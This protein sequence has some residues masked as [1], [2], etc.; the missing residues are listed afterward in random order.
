[1]KAAK[2]FLVSV[3][4][5]FLELALIR[6][7][8]S[9]I[10]AVGFFKNL[11]LIAAFLGLGLGLNLSLPPRLTFLLFSVCSLLPHLL[12]AIV[13]LA[14][15]GEIPFIG[16]Q[17][18]AV[19]VPGRSYVAGLVLLCIAFVSVILPMTF[20]GRLLGFLFDQFDRPLNAYGWNIL[21]SLLG[22][23]LFSVVCSFSAPP[24]SWF[25]AAAG[26][27]L[28]LVLAELRLLGGRYAV[29]VAVVSLVVIPLR[30]IASDPGELWTPYYKTRVYEMSYRS[31]EATG[32]GL[33]V[34][35]TWFQRSFD[36]AK[37]GRPE[38]L[39][40]EAH[41]ARA[42]RFFAPFRTA[43]PKTVLVL[44]SGLGNDTAA[45]L[46]FGVERVD[47]VDIDPVIVQL[48]NRY[49]PNEPYKNERVRVFVDDARH[50]LTSTEERYDLILFGVLEAR[51]L[52]SQ[53][54]NL[55]LDNY[56]YTVEALRQARSRLNEGG[57]VW[58][59]IWVPKR[60]ILQKFAGMMHEAFGEEFAVLAGR[61]SVHVSFVAGD[62]V[63]RA[64]LEAAA[65]KVPGVA[66]IEVPAP[67]YADVTTPTDDWPYVFYRSRQL[68]VSYL[69]LLGSLVLLS[70]GAF[71]IAQRAAFRIQW[72][73]FFLGA[74][75]LLVETN[76]VVRMALL[77]GTTWVVNSAV[78]AGV[79]IFI[80]LANWLVAKREMERTGPMFM[81]LFAVMAVAYFFPF[82][83]LLDLPNQLAVVIGAGV[84]T[85]PVFFASVVFS[86]LFRQV[87]VP[88]R[89]LASNLLGAIVGG[90]SEYLSM[91]LG[92]RAMSLVALGFYLLAFWGVRRGLSSVRE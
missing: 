21:G 4:L 76:S 55:R 6:Y 63:S 61:R 46:S 11:V 39:S 58:L 13:S 90:F 78:F 79:L 3:L 22:T 71:G 7:L 12:T 87:S 5:L 43:R 74:A 34:N 53:F 28:A 69:A 35:N 50:Y 41:A 48:S 44:G 51:S 77:A 23:L 75:F 56:V 42:L 80:F 18:E 52:F 14:G 82:H 47:A 84:L 37:L 24:M 16:V 31:G 1:M 72:S 26:L 83:R 38:E 62:G 45:A 85:L 60:W 54:A 67:P 57:L 40:E 49:H 9:E 20:L 86:T 15:F 65:T 19:L 33:E 92:N 2:L 68:P 81:A 17:D 66:V 8:S 70:F 89:A 30:W 29:V 59:N 10:P 27:F 64:D 36:V 32:Y 73:F 25:V 91:L 88:S